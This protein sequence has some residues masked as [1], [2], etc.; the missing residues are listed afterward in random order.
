MKT[1]RFLLFNALTGIFFGLLYLCFPVQGLAVF[2]LSTDVTGQ[3]MTRFFGSALTG[4]GFICLYE[5][6]REPSALKGLMTALLIGNVFGLV[7][8]FFAQMTGNP[9]MLCWSIV[10]IYLLLV[11]GYI[12]FLYFARDNADS[13]G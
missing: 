9:N 13:T 4:I 11:A 10:L 12:Y 7:V 2:D 8:A 6:Q 3:Y 5:R 1:D